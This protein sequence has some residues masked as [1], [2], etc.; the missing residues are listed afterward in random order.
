MKKFTRILV[1]LMLFVF[2]FSFVACGN[3]GKDKFVYPASNAKTEGNGGMSVQKGNYLY[4]VNGFKSVTSTDI[5]KKTNYN[6]G[7][8]KVAKLDENGN[9]V[10]GDGG[11][12]DDYYRTITDKLVGYEIADLHIFGDYIYFV[13]PCL[14]N[15]YVGGDQVWAKKKVV[16]YRTKINNKGKI[17]KLYQSRVDYTELDYNEKD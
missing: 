14:E 16:F 12:K 4:F 17:E 13:S 5:T 2:A 11:L 10:T 8:L 3:N 15:E 6:I 7:S 9:P 1:C